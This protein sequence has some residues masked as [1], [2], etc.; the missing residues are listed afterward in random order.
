MWA[1]YGS[2]YVKSHSYSF[3]LQKK[4]M[5]H[6]KRYWERREIKALPASW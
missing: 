3:R 2:D 1:L 4:N 5:S 6:A